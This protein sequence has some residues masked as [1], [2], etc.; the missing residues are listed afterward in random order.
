MKI[1]RWSFYGILMPLVLAGAGWS[2]GIWWLWASAAPSES[3]GIKIRITVPDGTPMQIIGEELEAAGVIRSS[4]ALR[5]WLQ[6]LGLKEGKSA[7]LQAGTYDFVTDKSLSDIVTQ[8]QKGQPLETS[9]TIPEGWSIAQMAN[10]FEKQGF[11]SA[12]DFIEAANNQSTIRS[13][14]WLPSGT[15]S[16]EGFLYPDTYQLPPADIKPDRVIE[17]MLSQFEQVALPVYNASQEKSSK[18]SISLKDWVTFAS[19]VEKEAVLDK[20]RPLIAGVFWQRLKRKMP[21]GSDPTVEYGLGIQQTPEK[22]L[23]LAQVRTASPYNTYINQGLPPAAIAAPS[24]KSL[25][26]VLK[27][28]TTDYLYFVARYDGSHTFSRTLDEHE[29]AQ[30]Q[31]GEQIDEQVKKQS[32]KTTLPK[33]Q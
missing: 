31:I 7:G 5:I 16:L 17:V 3:V 22:P 10:Y 9:F 26:A 29:K 6:W 23:T 21:L 28:E 20:E 32:E 33:Q 27:P 18:V 15:L 14:N 19:I 24:L 4:L 8:M 25:Q 11:F 30:R 12:K 2:G 13:R 1:P